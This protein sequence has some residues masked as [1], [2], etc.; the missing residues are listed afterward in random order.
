[1]HVCSHG[2]LHAPGFQRLRPRARAAGRAR[3]RQ[4]RLQLPPVLCAG[5]AVVEHVRLH[6][7]GGGLHLLRELQ[8]RQRLVVAIGGRTRRQQQHRS[9]RPSEGLLQQP[10]D[11][12][13]PVRDMALLVG[14]RLHNAQHCLDGG[15]ALLP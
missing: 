3:R 14:D 6:R 4:R 11:L 12:R 8:Q 2:A 13:V 7:V 10:C 5:P 1:V 9:G 15:V